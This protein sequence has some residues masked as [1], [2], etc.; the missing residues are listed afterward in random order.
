MT[1]PNADETRAPAEGAAEP[2]SCQTLL[3]A[4]DRVLST[5]NKDG[6][7]RW[8]RP[9]VSA[10]R[11]LTGR[12]LVAY[13][14]MVVFVAVPFI[15]V[16]GKP[17]ILLDVVSREF[18]LLG[19]TFRPT[20]TPIL[21]LLLLAIF[22]GIFLIT[23]LF[24]RVW[25]GWACPQ[26]VYM[27]FLYRP[28]ERL[29]EGSPQE[30]A[31]LDREGPSGRRLLKYGV[32][33]A[34]SFV[35]ANTFLAYFVGVERLST[36]VL[37][38]PWERPVGFTV[39]AATTAL[40]MW[41]FGFFREQMCIITCPYARFQSAL[42]DRHSLIVGYDPARG[43]PRG[44]PKKQKG[45]DGRALP[46]VPA[47]QG[48]C[49][50]CGA[51]VVTCPTGIDIRDGLQMECI[52]C[53]QCIDACDAIMAKV[54][55][56]P[57]LIRY[58]SEAELAGEPKRVIRPRVVIYT[59]LLL[60]LGVG[61]A[62]MLGGRDAVRVSLLRERTPFAVLGTGE[63]QNLLKL[64]LENQ[65]EVDQA[66]SVRLEGAPSGRL[67]VAEDP[68]E[69]DPREHREVTL[70]VLL[71]RDAIADGERE[72]RFEVRNGAGELVEEVPYRFVGPSDGPNAGGGD[73]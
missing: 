11:F 52:G 47:A 45:A 41:D 3:A 40:M 69:L 14:L 59:A 65:T 62:T 63:V 61:L 26:T 4:P 66:V 15:H 56:P 7:R 1:E 25:C 23:A 22:F 46:V 17:L 55:K 19:T 28:L 36:W 33:L 49:I 73:Q 29:L 27:E 68:I 67:I 44:K 57:G 53:A 43:E 51:C 58:D 70:I 34:V 9:R 30:Q 10:G 31:K 42:L 24:G 13:L 48:D 20:D 21:M 64:K 35:L 2:G 60:A 50:D 72:V 37:R 71:P 8:L 32:F 5:L 18:H 6:T 39:V 38:P 16:N 54:G 12:R